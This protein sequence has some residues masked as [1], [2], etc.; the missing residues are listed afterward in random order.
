MIQWP[1]SR[2]TLAILLIFF[3]SANSKAIELFGYRLY[4]DILQY[5]NDGNVNYKKDKIENIEIYEDRVQISNK[6]LNQYMIKSTK[7]GNIFEIHG[8]NK[9]LEMSP[10]ECLDVQNKFIKS[11]ENKNRDIYFTEIKQFP[12]KLKSK[13][14]WEVYLIEKIN[15]KEL[16]FS[17][18]CDYSFNNRRMDII[19]NDLNF[20]ENENYLFDQEADIN[21]QK[22]NEKNI[23]T[24]G[25]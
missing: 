15:N 13:T 23:D 11:F 25:I 24:S 12:N 7:F 1:M 6:Y 16:I 5:Q 18:T 2:L 8:S 21:N 17:V 9:Q 14:I 4:E 22:A 20:L 3:T 19:L 10:V